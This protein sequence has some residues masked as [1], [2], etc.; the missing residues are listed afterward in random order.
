MCPCAFKASAPSPQSNVL[1]C[2]LHLLFNVWF[3]FSVLAWSY[4]V[5]LFLCT[6]YAH[7]SSIS[8]VSASGVETQRLWR[9]FRPPDC[10]FFPSSSFSSSFGRSHLVLAS[11][12]LPSLCICFPLFLLLCGYDTSD[13]S[14]NEYF[15]SVSTLTD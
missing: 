11:H 10:I 13:G 3:Q 15:F 2:F 5:F 7:A 4:A 8:P 12:F 1:S 6:Q 14:Y 9:C